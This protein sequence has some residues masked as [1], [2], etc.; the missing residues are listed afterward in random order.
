M[1]RYA[2]IGQPVKHSLSPRIHAAFATATGAALRYEAIEIAPEM[3]AERLCELHA[4]G[5]GGLNVTLP[6]KTAA[7]A[8]C[9]SLSDRARHAEAANVL[10]RTGSGW[11][12]DNSDGVGLVADVTRN[13]GVAL[14]GKRLLV[15]GSGGAARGILAPLLEAGPAEL[16][17]SNRSPWTPEELAP[18]FATLGP[19]RPSTHLALKGDRFDVVFNATSVGHQGGVPRLPDGLFAPG[20]L[21]YDLNYGAAAAPFLDW[22][23]GQGAARTADGLGMLVEQ[24]AESFLLWRGTRPPTDDVLATLRR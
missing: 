23:R 21:A 3:L 18:R 22:A 20:G 11:R 16:V 6:H 5:Y 13:L 19:I 1:D 8:L 9:E 12:G 14:A 17:L 10:I 4:H 7:A 15:L 24:A 2:V